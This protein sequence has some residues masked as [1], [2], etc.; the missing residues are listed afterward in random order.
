MY[1]QYLK[2]GTTKNGQGVFTSIRI[3]A[4]V[5]VMEITGPLLQGDPPAGADYS[6]YLQVGVN[7]F[8]SLSGGIDDAVGHSCDPNCL[9]QVV[10]NRAILYSLYVIPPNGE[11]NFDYSTT[12]TDSPET[13][14]MHCKCGSNKCRK[15]ISGFNYLDFALRERYIRNDMV[16]LFITNPGL[17]QK[18]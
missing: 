14:E 11:V 12:S 18:V 5:P 8:I 1:D 17:I 13:W 16:P 9:M 6:A 2:V 10:G 7:S 4:G 15:L 3:P